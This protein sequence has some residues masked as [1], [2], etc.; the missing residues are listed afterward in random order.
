MVG[1]GYSWLQKYAPNAGAWNVA[2][3]N[4]WFFALGRGALAYPDFGRA[5]AETGNSK[6]AVF[7]KP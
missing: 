4:I 5:L 7:A 2:N 6:S 3:G 1:A